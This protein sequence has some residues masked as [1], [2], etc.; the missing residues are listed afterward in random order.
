MWTDASERGIGIN[1]SGTFRQ[2]NAFPSFLSF[3]FSYRNDTTY[4]GHVRQF[5]LFPLFF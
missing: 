1:Y 3:F 5:V 2:L 4:A